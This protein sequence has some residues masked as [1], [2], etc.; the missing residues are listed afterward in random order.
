MSLSSLIQFASGARR[1]QKPVIQSEGAECGL[2]CITMVANALGHDVDILSLRAKQP[3]GRGGLSVAALVRMASSLHL[4]AR[5]V[6]VEPEHLEHLSNPAILHWRMQHYV[7]LRGVSGGKFIIDDPNCGRRRVTNSE[8]SQDFT[9]IAIEFSR[10]TEFTPLEMRR[11]TKLGDVLGKLT[12]WKSPALL[13]LFFSLFAQLGIVA[14][15]MVIQFAVDRVAIAGNGDL[16]LAAL[17]GFLGVAS[18][19][20]LAGLLRDWTM[21]YIGNGILFQTVLRI[22]SHLQRL[23]VSFFEMRHVG[24]IISRI[25]SLQPIQTALTRGLVSALLD[26]A[27]ALFLF[28]IILFYSIPLG[29]FA[30]ATTAVLFS[31]ILAFQNVLRRQQ[32]EQLAHSAEEQSFLMETIRNVRAIQIF[33]RESERESAWQNKYAQVLNKTAAAS[34]TRALMKF[35]EELILMFQL[36]GFI[37]IGVSALINANTISIGALAALLAFRQLLAARLVGF[38]EEVV[39]LRLLGLHLN[40]LGDI[41]HANAQPLISPGADFEANDEIFGALRLDKVA[42]AY[43]GVNRKVFSDVTLDIPAKS[44]VALIGRSGAGKSTLLKVMLGLLD[45]VEGRV[46][47]D[48][49]PLTPHSLRVWRRHVGVVMQDDRVF[50]GTILENVTFF[51]PEPDMRAA[52]EACLQAEMLDF[53]EGLPMGFNTYIGNLGTNLSGGEVQRLF[54]ARALYRKPKLLFLDEGTANLDLEVEARIGETIASLP[55]TRVVIA[56]RPALVER[57]DHVFSM[58]DGKITR[59]SSDILSSGIV[60]RSV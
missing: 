31:V 25:G 3:V 34:R 1:S 5:V 48:G 49:A 9:G 20:A 29:I 40:R 53:I 15:P 35:C 59:V 30:I 32:E 26:G 13:I 58:E 22:V 45:P 36:A 50:T 60:R 7:V 54:L 17:I 8:L 28:L 41:I 6:R 16:L 57:A 2:A 21:I 52:R 27:F 38:V 42:Y 37:Y 14:I 19:T 51:D 56:H 44:F 10:K 24:D 11:P 55:I 4:S 33:G 39:Q 47:F 43:P 23:P 12:G 18:I 46:H